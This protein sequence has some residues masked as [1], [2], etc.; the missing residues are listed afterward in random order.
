MAH[1]DGSFG[2]DVVDAVF[3]SMGG[4]LFAAFANAPLFAQPAAV[5]NITGHQ[6]QHTN[7]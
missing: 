7:D 5:E 3:H 2:G 4:G 6:D 1:Q